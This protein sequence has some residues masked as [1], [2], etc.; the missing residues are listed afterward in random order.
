M[1]ALKTYDL[2]IS[3]VWKRSENSEYVRL[4]DL[5]KGAP[6]FSWRN[7]SVPEH[8]PL[9]TKTDAELKA[10][11]DAQIK[12][13]NSVLIVSGMY[14]NYR[15]WIQIEIEIAKKYNKPMIGVI[16]WGQERTPTEVQAVV[17]EMVNWN[18]G[19]IVEAIRKYSL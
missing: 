17:K 8:D 3:H 13:V 15:K 18:T 19:S 14:V 5:L 10:A 7:Y 9:E 12:P 2:F 11:L 16:P 6:N 4:V 1:P